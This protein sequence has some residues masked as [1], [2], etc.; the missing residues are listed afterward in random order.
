MKMYLNYNGIYKSGVFAVS[1]AEIND[2]AEIILPQ[3]FGEITMAD[4]SKAIEWPDGQITLAT[5]IF[6]EHCEETAVP[7]IV[8][9]SGKTPKKLYLKSIKK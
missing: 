7:Y 8:D 3:G 4:G 6:T 1:P 5:Q 9:C 2:E